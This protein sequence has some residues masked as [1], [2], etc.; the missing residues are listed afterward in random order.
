MTKRPLAILAL[1]VFLPLAAGATPLLH[2][3]D[4]HDSAPC[5]VCYL[6][7]V[8][9][10]A[11]AIGLALLLMAAQ[12]TRPSLWPIDAEAHSSEHHTPA[13]PRAPPSPANAH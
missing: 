12:P 3:H 6:V 11:L 8:G 4:H 1:L 9:S 13:A 7:K 5:Q 2:H 10:V